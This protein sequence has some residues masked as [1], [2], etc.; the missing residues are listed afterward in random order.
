MPEYTL[1]E[2]AMRRIAAVVKAY[3][4]G[5]L[6]ATPRPRNRRGK[7]DPPNFYVRAADAIDDGELGTATILAGSGSSSITWT[8]TE[9][10]IEI[11]IGI[12]DRNFN[13]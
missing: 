11:L 12:T 2:D 6:S 3:E 7:Q 13:Y 9:Q 5:E 8:D 4:R 1:T 10:E